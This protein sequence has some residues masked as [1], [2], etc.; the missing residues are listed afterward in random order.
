[1]LNIMT[2]ILLSCPGVEEKS[3]GREGTC[4]PVRRKCLT[5]YQ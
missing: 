2:N 5:V 1:M 3:E 4:A